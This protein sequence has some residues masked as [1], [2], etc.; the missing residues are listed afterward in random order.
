VGETGIG[1]WKKVDIQV[2]ND[3][4]I[5]NSEI[6]V[7]TKGYPGGIIEIGSGGTCNWQ[8]SLQKNGFGPYGGEAG[9]A[10]WDSGRARGSGGSNAGRGYDG[11]SSSG[12]GGIKY[13]PPRPGS[14]RGTKIF[15]FGSGGGAVKDGGWDNTGDPCLDGGDGGGRI[16]LKV[17]GKL[18]LDVNSKITANGQNGKAVNSTD[19]KLARSGGGAGG[20][21]F[22]DAPTISFPYKGTPSSV[23]PGVLND[24][25]GIG[26]HS[27]S[28]FGNNATYNLFAIGG[29]S[30]ADA[31]Y[32]GAGGG[33]GM[34]YVEKPA[35][36]N[37]T[38]KKI[39][40]PVGRPRTTTNIDFNPYALKADDRIRVRLTIANISGN[41]NLSDDLLST[42]T[43]PVKRCDISGTPTA[44][45]GN[46]NAVNRNTTVTP[47]KLDFTGITPDA[48]GV[49]EI[50]Y[51]CDVN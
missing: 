16:H 50:V 7:D 30:A 21:I 26:V 29:S 51:L 33:G 10:G 45:R 41:I 2:S 24:A 6:N 39:L 38:V 12:E 32:K 28:G 37:I 23:E 49:A 46:Y 14:Y 48:S 43:A 11:E 27:V 31:T 8:T 18:E 36:N 3:F 22:I 13:D 42:A 19:D 17:D 15:D 25:E 1:R 4:I 44:I 47:Y 35:K 40:E 20:T 34:I 5:N 9:S